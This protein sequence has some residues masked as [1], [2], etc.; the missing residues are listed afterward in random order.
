MADWKEQSLRLW[1]TIDK[2]Q[3]YIIGGVALLL[4]LFILGWSYWWGGRPEYVSLYTNMEAKDAGDVAAKLKELKIPYEIGNGGTSIMVSSKDVYRV[5][6]E[7]ASI[8]LPR[9]NKGFEIFDQ[10]KFGVTEF[11]NKVYLLQALQGELARTIEQFSEVEKAR[12]HIVMPEDSLYRKNEKPASASIMLKL[13]PNAQISKD[14]V[15]GIVNL[16]AHS[17]QGLKP[18]NITVLDSFA[19][20]L[21]EEE[22]TLQIGAKANLTFIEL[23]KKVQDG[24]QKSAQSMLEQVLGPGKAAVRVNVELNFD[25]R[26][27]DRQIFQ[28][29]VDDKGVIRSMQETTETYKG[30]GSSPGGTPGV[31]SNI[32]GYVTNSNNNSQSDYDKKEVTRNYEINET[33]EKVVAAPGSIKRLTVSV[34]VDASVGRQQQDSIAKVISSA[35][36]LNPARGD[37]IAVEVIPFSSEAAERQRK[38]ELSFE[39]QQAT[40]DLY[41]KIG[42]GAAVALLIIILL[43]RMFKRRQLEEVQI[44][45]NVEET[46]AAD[47]MPMPVEKQLTPE[48]K[49]KIQQKETIDKLAKSKPEEVAQ[50]IRAW[51]GDE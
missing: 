9:G 50:L 37:A 6:L 11:Q 45:T 41:L 48:D 20:V 31:A 16:V 8:G 34:L 21:N 44:V 3:R 47:E 49:E 51:I 26:V 30:V 33:K 19:R 4:F 43:L 12:V 24:L 35:V 42:A 27:V 22:D 15:K 46:E 2:R 39:Q 32:P 36:G 38:E 5:R 14:Q 17:I 7:L 18:D 13:R 23:T 1:Q 28:P 40:R 25:Q 29:V 10:N